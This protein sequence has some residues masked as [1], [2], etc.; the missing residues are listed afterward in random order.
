MQGRS[1]QLKSSQHCTW[2]LQPCPKP[3]MDYFKRGLSSECDTQALPKHQVKHNLYSS[4]PLGGDSDPGSES[5]DETRLREPGAII[6]LGGT[7]KDCTVSG[8]LNLRTK[9]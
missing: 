3:G 6:L 5:D 9:Y 7:G 8:K 1:S 4:L 2:T